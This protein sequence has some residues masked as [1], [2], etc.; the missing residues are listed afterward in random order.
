MPL[1]LGNTKNDCVH[2]IWSNKPYAHRLYMCKCTLLKLLFG[3]LR[4]WQ[5]THY[6]SEKQK[7]RLC[8]FA[9]Q[10]NGPATTHSRAPNA[11]SAETASPLRTPKSLC[12]HSAPCLT[13]DRPPSSIPRIYSTK[14][15][16]LRHIYVWVFRI[17][18]LVQWT[19]ES[20]TQSVP[21]RGSTFNL[22]DFRVKFPHNK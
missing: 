10:G 13:L 6:F 12:L 1:I 15:R 9:V 8:N 5:R 18:Y 20:R 2:L 16:Y 11:Q 4:S 14:F 17:W 22:F 3:K 7:Y 19:L 21:R